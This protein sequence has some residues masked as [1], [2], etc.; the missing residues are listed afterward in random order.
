MTTEGVHWCI[1]E[2]SIT[3]EDAGEMEAGYLMATCKKTV[4]KKSVKVVDK[5]NF[6]STFSETNLG[7]K[8]FFFT[9]IFKQLTALIKSFL[10][11]CKTWLLDCCAKYTSSLPACTAWPSFLCLPLDFYPSKTNVVELYFNFQEYV[12]NRVTFICATL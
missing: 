6:L 7:K 11:W 2:G 10:Y 1:E 9:Y 8:I 12:S 4:K 5:A 3:V